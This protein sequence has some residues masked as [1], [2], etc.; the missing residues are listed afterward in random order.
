[1]L[2]GV[3]FASEKMNLFDN[4]TLSDAD[5]AKD[6]EILSDAEEYQN[7][8]T[9]LLDIQNIEDVP[10]IASSS[11]ELIEINKKD[12]YQFIDNFDMNNLSYEEYI[13]IKSYINFNIMHSVNAEETEIIE[14]LIIS[15]TPVGTIKE[16]YEFY[17]TTNDDF[18][19][20]EK[21]AGYEE[22]YWGKY[23]IENAYNDITKNEHGVIEL[24]ESEEYRE[25]YDVSEIMYANVLS[26]KGVYTI[27]EVLQ[28]HADGTSWNELTKEIYS[29][30]ASDK[31]SGSSKER[32]ELCE[33][34]KN[35]IFDYDSSPYEVYNFAFFCAKN[36]IEL[37]EGV[38]NKETLALCRQ[39]AIENADE[40]LLELSAKISN[41]IN[42][43]EEYMSAD[44]LNEY[45][46]SNYNKAIENGI[47]EKT[48]EM[49]LDKGLTMGEIAET[50][51]SSENPV[52]IV[53]HIK[54]QRGDML[55]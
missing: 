31:L 16:I 25:K 6:K 10:I 2:L 13:T 33:Y 26:R 36:K 14:K 28:R 29:A 47:D 42:L 34:L 5:V 49:L 23:W 4:E 8:K 44:E 38:I 19:I 51:V 20:V 46:E 18:S 3:S 48:I 7:N 35:E 53:Q 40:L 1:M 43:P 54:S 45:N 32:Y 50:G 12:K 37:K 11:A 9:G 30:E 22:R 15:G 39:Q 41:E 55:K 21:L 24:K 52:G 17:L 27:K